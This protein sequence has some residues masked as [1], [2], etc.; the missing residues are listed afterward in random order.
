MKGI[1]EMQDDGIVHIKELPIGKW[2]KD[3]KEYIEEIMNA[4]NTKIMSMK[5]YHT[6]NRVHFELQL[7]DAYI[8]QNG[9]RIEHYQK[10]FKL[11]SSISMRNM[12][13]FNSAKRLQ[14]Y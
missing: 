4:G 10:L 14:R 8:R 12:V 2:T 7:N 3:Y 5:E 13:G 11:I 6:K 1:V 9:D